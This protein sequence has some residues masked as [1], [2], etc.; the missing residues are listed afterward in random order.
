MEWCNKC[1]S[2]GRAP[3]D[4]W[5]WGCKAIEALQL[6]LNRRWASGEARSLAEEI[7]LSAAR[8]V[9]ALGALG[10]TALRGERGPRGDLVLSSFPC[11]S[12]RPGALGSQKVATASAVPVRPRA[13]PPPVGGEA[14]GGKERAEQVK[15]VT[16]AKREAPS[17]YEYD[18]YS[19]ES[20]DPREPAAPLA[21]AKSS[22]RPTA[23]ER[24]PLPRK[25]SERKHKKKKKQK[26]DRTQ[27]SGRKH[28]R[29]QSGP[30]DRAVHR[31]LS[32]QELD[33][34]RGFQGDLLPRLSES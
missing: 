24:S 32:E 20:W 15:P 16:S 31:R 19:E 5:C 14:G 7:C 33:I 2:G 12:S 8:Q 17:Q 29:I 27:R 30:P 18:Y 23:P 26:K 34:G 1:R 25:A 10:S 6:E 22:A 9:R 28:Q 4:S 13:T 11:E 3:N 21:S